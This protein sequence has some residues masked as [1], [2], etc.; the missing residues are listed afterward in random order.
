M[1]KAGIG[2]MLLL[3]AVAAAS[4]AQEQAAAQ[5]KKPVLLELFTS[6]GCSSCPPADRLLASLDQEQ[7]FPGM[8]LIVLSEHVDYWNGPSWHDPFSSHQLTERQASYAELFKIE[9]IYTPQLV[10]DGQRQA[11]GGNAV[12][13]R[14]AIEAVAQMPKVSLVLSSVAR[15]GDAVKVHVA[16]GPLGGSENKATLYLAIAQEKAQ[17]TVSGGENGGHILTHVAVVRSL[18]SVDRVG[19]GSSCSKDLKISVPHS[20]SSPLRIVVFLQEE[21]SGKVLGVAQAKL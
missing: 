7:P 15:D 11:V 18:K 10:V 20:S 1:S 16:A 12:A 4:S 21:K 13:V 14:S 5:P 2:T 6:E 3:A 8:E 17:S 19:P 9:D